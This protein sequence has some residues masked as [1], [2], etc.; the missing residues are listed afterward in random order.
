MDFEIYPVS[1]IPVSDV[2]FL[3]HDKI[4][5][6]LKKF[7]ESD[8]IIT[9][10][11]IAIHGDWGSGKTGIMLSLSKKLDPTK[12]DIVFFEA[13][14]FEYSNPAM[15]LLGTIIQKY[16]RESTAIKS[17]LRAGGTI[18]S[19]KYLDMDI[20]QLIDAIKGNTS[21]TGNFSDRLKIILKK[22]LKEKNLV[23]IIDDLDRC[24]VENTLQI[25]ALMKLFL[26]IDKVICIVAVDLNRL[27][28]AWKQ[29]YGDMGSD[30]QVGYL[31]KIFQ[32]K[33]NLHT[34]TNEQI[35][36]FLQELVPGI[37]ED[38]LSLFSNLLNKNPRAIKRTLNL[39]SYR[40]LLL[41]SN[42]K[43]LSASLWTILEE[44]MTIK[45][46][47]AL[48]E[49]LQ[50]NGNSLSHLIFTNGQNW[51]EIKNS[52]I[53][54]HHL[55]NAKTINHDKI[56]FYFETTKTILDKLTVDE[57]SLDSDF[58]IMYSTTKQE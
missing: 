22:H 41:S 38:V 48:Y 27:Q 31:D 4:V 9:P 6:N 53:D 28:Q 26:D 57:K 23:I 2:K 34:P 36:D 44:I 51:N 10:L 18:L 35:R 52:V 54:K 29:K 13:W 43:Q 11:S 15:G 49:I 3:G 7:L 32:I 16:E 58:Q 19:N 45:P 20:T 8:K 25:L 42:H 5:E 55:L 46:L 12:S 33:I 14:K 56:K 17:F 37:K 21:E 50:K 40:Q 1:D 24:D 47:I 39:I 30:D